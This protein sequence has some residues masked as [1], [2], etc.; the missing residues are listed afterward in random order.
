MVQRTKGLQA[1]DSFGSA[2]A[3]AMSNI[4]IYIDNVSMKKRYPKGHSVAK[5]ECPSV[6]H[7]RTS[8]IN[9]STWHLQG[10]GC[11][12]AFG[13]SGRLCCD[14]W[15]SSCSQDSGNSMKTYRV[16]ISLEGCP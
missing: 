6:A 14:L 16:S 10:L 4:Y 1:L 5:I 15:W 8:S 12:V 13:P 9:A 2:W 3:W 7:G 11:V